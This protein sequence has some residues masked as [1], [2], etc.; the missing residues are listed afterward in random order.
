MRIEKTITQ[1]H[2][3]F[4]LSL[5]DEGGGVVRGGIGLIH[6]L[7]FFKEKNQ[8]NRII[9]HSAASLW[10]NIFYGENSLFARSLFSGAD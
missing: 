7:S 1:A 6:S 3:Q 8:Y 4:S 10:K 9:N 5:K 2:R